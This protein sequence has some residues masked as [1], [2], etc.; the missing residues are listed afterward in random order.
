MSCGRVAPQQNIK[1][2]IDVAVK[3]AMVE[4]QIRLENEA[5]KKILEL[6]NKLPTPQE[7]LEKL[8]SLLCSPEAMAKMEQIYNFFE[9][10]LSGILNAL[11]KVKNFLNKILKKIQ[12]ILTNVLEKINGIVEALQPTLKILKKILLVAPI[13]L[14]AMVGLAA[15]GAVIQKLAKAMAFAEDLICTFMAIVN[16]V[17]KTVSKYGQKAQ[18]IISIIQQAYNAVSQLYDRVDQLR[19]YLEFLYAAFIQNCALEEEGEE[20]Y[21]EE[22]EEWEEN[23]LIEITSDDILDPNNKFSHLGN[24][25]PDLLSAALQQYIDELNLMDPPYQ[26]TAERIYAM[27]FN[28]IN[29]KMEVDHLKSYQIKLVVNDGTQYKNY[30]DVGPSDLNY[31]GGPVNPNMFNEHG[32]I[33]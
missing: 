8:S 31:Q 1:A 25:T 22:E 19:M 15:N 7:L 12:K 20:V 30:F 21:N 28:H 3:K 24:S 17:Q 33:F 16:F 32:F 4:A 9:K 29:L 27:R 5:R 26:R 23:E 6:K 11:D 14:G 10:L 18:K 13:A 2:Q